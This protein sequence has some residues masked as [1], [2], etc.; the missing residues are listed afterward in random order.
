VSGASN[1]VTMRATVDL[2]D[3]DSPTSPTISPR[4]IA[5]VTFSAAVNS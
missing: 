1:P 2:P 4:R 5:N 3:P